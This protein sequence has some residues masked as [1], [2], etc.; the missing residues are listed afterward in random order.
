MKSL[1]FLGLHFSSD[2]QSPGTDVQRGAEP[3]GLKGK[4]RGKNLSQCLSGEETQI[5]P[6]SCHSPIVKLG[7]VTAL[8][9]LV[10]CSGEQGSG[11]GCQY[12]L[13]RGSG[14]IC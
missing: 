8:S 2:Y 13:P 14:G 5:K 4:D 11:G 6:Q 10:S 12:I 7:L 9:K 1:C 3:E